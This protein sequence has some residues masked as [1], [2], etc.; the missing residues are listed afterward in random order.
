VPTTAAQT[1]SV[2]PAPQRIPNYAADTW[3]PVLVADQNRTVHA[4]ASQRVRSGTGSNVT[5][6]VYS[7]WSPTQGWTAAVDVL[8]SPF[9]DQARLLDVL[10]DPSGRAHLLFW[11][12]DGT[13][14][15]I[16]YSSAAIAEAGSNRAWSAP[17]LIAEQAGDP[18]TGVIYANGEQRITILFSGRREG[19]GVYRAHSE[20]NGQSWSD[21]VLLFST[22]VAGNLVHGLQVSKGASGWVH[23]IWSERTPADQGRF[24]FYARTPEAVAEWSAPIRLAEAEAGFGT[25]TPAIIALHDEVLAFFNLEG[26]IYQRSSTDGT[27]W[28][29]PQRLFARHTGVNGSLSPVVDGGDELHL[30]FAQRI[31]GAPDIHGMW[32]SR[33]DGPAWTEPEPLVAGP[34]IDDQVG[35]TGFDPFQARAV[36]SQ[37]NVLLVTWRSD[38]GM[39][40]NGVWYSYQ[41]IEAPDVPLATPVPEAAP[42]TSPAAPDAAPSPLAATL[43]ASQA[44]PEAASE[45]STTPPGANS[46][47]RVLL[48]STAPVLLL[49]G[50][51][52]IRTLL[53]GRA[54]K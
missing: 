34:M 8:L 41:A 38:P 7:R 48:I 47:A 25:N 36:V 37:G 13:G 51:A 29:A 40:G 46:P 31:T 15:N 28:T 27:Q 39:K 54:G 10:L 17:L 35:E 20:D 43:V 3:P 21:P 4:F 2:W 16:Y 19:T 24:V 18:E 11:G 32:H 30:F 14:A 1:I 33:R 9:K 5:A 26:T 49:L 22:Q 23:A 12:G 52:L 53:T 42:A 44:T 6:I 50:L 45:I